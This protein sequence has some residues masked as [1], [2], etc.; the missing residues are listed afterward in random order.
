M[1]S[2]TE[3]TEEMSRLFTYELD[4]LSEKD[5]LVAKSIVGK[6]VT[7]SVQY[8]DESC[9]FNGFVSRFSPCGRGDRLNLGTPRWFPALVL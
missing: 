5:S 7:F 1:R 9:Y 6:N 4:L 8:H 2:F 3:G